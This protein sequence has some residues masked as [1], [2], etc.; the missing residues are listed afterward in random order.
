MSVDGPVLFARY[1]YPP[2]SLGYCGPDAGR[3]LLERV[4]AA[5]AAP[6]PDGATTSPTVRP[7]DGGLRRL[8]RS[9][10]GAWPYLELIAHENG[11]ADPLDP[12]V[13]EAYWVGNHL[14]RSVTPRAFGE[15]LATRFR[16][17]GRAVWSGVSDAL[18]TGLAGA[19]HHGFH[20]L[21]VYPW[22]GLLRSGARDEP[23][24]VLDRCRVR[25][26]QVVQV[27]ADRA[28]VRS[29]PLR[30]DGHR[31]TE[32]PPVLEE[33]VRARDGY[34]L[35]PGLAP[36]DWCSMHWDWVCDR[37]DRR[38]VVALR[39]WTARQLDLVDALARPPGVLADA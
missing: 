14:L 29:R 22:V 39:W 23:L 7:D 9:F 38:G 35:A 11:L 31:L 17:H 26:G 27:S 10:E 15:C 5:T 19:P 34:G 24:R 6:A 8:A 13:V 36:G 28:L 18:A 4:S 32:G 30:W 3:E 20:V 1:A 25:P 12:R 16:G 33:V 37:L 2:N 21:A